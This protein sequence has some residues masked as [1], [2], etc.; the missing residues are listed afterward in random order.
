MAACVRSRLNSAS[1]ELSLG[2]LDGHFFGLRSAQISSRIGREPQAALVQDLG[3]E[4]LLFAQQAE[5]QVLGA[6]VLVVQALGFLGAIRQHA[7]ALVAERQIDRGRNLLADGGVAFDLLAD[8]F[9][10]RVRPQKAVGQRLV[11][12]Q[13]AEQQVLGFDIRAAE[14]AGLVT[15]EEDDPPGFFR[16]TFK[17]NFVPLCTLYFLGIQRLGPQPVRGTSAPPSS[18]RTR[19]QRL[20][21]DR[22]CVT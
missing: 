1:S 20:A 13:Q 10:G 9:D 21:N 17:H 16:I 5:Q 22:L 2:R 15:R 14:L 11:F 18:L 4:A 6:D 7:L 3:G 19:S 12:A 8:G